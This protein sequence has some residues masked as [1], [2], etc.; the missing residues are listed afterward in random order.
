MFF[1]LPLV[2][3]RA[4]YRFFVDAKDFNEQEQVRFLPTLAHPLGHF[5]Q[6]RLV[7]LLT[8]L[9]LSLDRESDCAATERIF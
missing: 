9:F 4:D 6:K 2:R 5:L 1:C 8:R 3:S 7:C